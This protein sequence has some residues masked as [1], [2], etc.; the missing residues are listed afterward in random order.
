MDTGR[1]AIETD[2]IFITAVGKKLTID[3]LGAADG[4][5]IVCSARSGTVRRAFES[6]ADL[7]FMVRLLK[8]RV[9]QHTD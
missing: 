5:C 7:E 2:H 8:G 3:F 4:F 6:H 9:G 1:L